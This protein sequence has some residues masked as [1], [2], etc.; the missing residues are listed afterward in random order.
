MTRSRPSTALAVAAMTSGL[1]LVAAAPAAASDATRWVSPTEGSSVT[2]PV[3]LTVSTTDDTVQ[4]FA[5]GSA[6]SGA[7]ARGSDGYVRATTS[8]S[9]GTHR[10]TAT[11]CT[12]DLLMRTTCSGPTIT[13]SVPAPAPG[14]APAPAPDSYPRL[15]ALNV[16]SLTPFS[17]NGDGVADLAI[18]RVVL[19][20][21]PADVV[22]DVVRDGRTVVTVPQGHRFPADQRLS[23]DG[24]IG[25]RPAPE[26]DYH[27]VPRI[28]GAG[29]VD[30]GGFSDV[31]TVDL[32]GPIAPA[33]SVPA[34]FHP[35][36]DGVDDGF[37]AYTTVAATP[38]PVVT[39]ARAVLLSGR[40]VVARGAWSGAD[41]GLVTTTLTPRVR[42][43]RYRAAIELQDEIGDRR[44]TPSRPI[45]ATASRAAPGSGARALRPSSTPGAGFRS[46]P[47][48]GT[49]AARGATIVIASSKAC[50]DGYSGVTLFPGLPDGRYDSVTLTVSGHGRGSLVVLDPVTDEPLANVLLSSG[51]TRVALPGRA[52]TVAP[53]TLV[54]GVVARGGDSF[55]I[56]GLRLDYRG[57]LIR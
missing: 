35:V 32:T 31:V 2:S 56:T 50:S 40:R 5:D 57:R 11:G 55:T 23:W 19:E 10:L 37:T 14:P 9:A 3:N 47:V 54:M 49:S 34:R 36:R 20:Q 27:L 53:H 30:R 25:G 26:G 13:V 12:R 7:I 8:L 44:L 45:L 21:G 38:Y 18:L 24:H 39:R 15:T 28:L 41:A 51:S 52:V 48:C 33:P 22:L 43:G 4:F 1:L 29:T 6:V 17:P 16:L 42:P 46:A